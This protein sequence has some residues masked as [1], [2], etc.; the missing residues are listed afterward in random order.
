MFGDD[1]KRG[2]DGHGVGAAEV[3]THVVDQLVS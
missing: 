2:F 1:A 3:Q